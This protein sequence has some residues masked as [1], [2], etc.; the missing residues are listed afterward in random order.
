MGM[1]SILQSRDVRSIISQMDGA[2][3]GG[4]ILTA[5]IINH[6]NYVARALRKKGKMLRDSHRQVETILETFRRS[7]EISTRAG[8]NPGRGPCCQPDASCWKI[9]W[10]HSCFSRRTRKTREQNSSDFSV[11]ANVI[12]DRCFGTRCRRWILDH[13][14]A[15]QKNLRQR[16]QVNEYL[17]TL[18][19]HKFFSSENKTECNQ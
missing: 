3:E 15:K 2:L 1:V 5:S 14:P 19:L 11:G 10:Q 8:G 18:H 13:G 17:P 4:E 7:R 6:T 12:R 9:H 16:N